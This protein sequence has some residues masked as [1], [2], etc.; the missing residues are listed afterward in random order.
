[1][2]SRPST[3]NE[4]GG[5]VCL[6]G[7]MLN[8]S[9]RSVGGVGVGGAATAT[10]EGPG[11]APIARQAR[12]SSDPAITCPHRVGRARGSRGGDCPRKCRLFGSVPLPQNW[13]CEVSDLELKPPIQGSIRV[14]VLI[15]SCGR[16]PLGPLSHALVGRDF[17]IVPATR[18]V[19]EQ[20]GWIAGQPVT[21]KRGAR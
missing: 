4:P 12:S 6:R 16:G 8:G 2:L 5:R 3:F 20:P 7:S 19:R 14:V 15:G 21:P 11:P 17:Q 10:A 18:V 13:N 9:K 1:M